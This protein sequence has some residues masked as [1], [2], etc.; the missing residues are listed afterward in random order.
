MRRARVFVFPSRYEGFGLPPL[1]A[2]RLGVPTV[3]S[4]EGALPEVCGDG[5]LQVG[6]DDVEGL[7]AAIG[8][9]DAALGRRGRARA[10]QFQWSKTARRTLEIYGVQ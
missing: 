6:P 5:A 1:E 3:V 8:K 7:A 4:T 10:Q 9:A 2:M